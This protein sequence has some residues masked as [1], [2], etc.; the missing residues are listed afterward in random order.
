MTAGP[1]PEVHCSPGVVYVCRDCDFVDERP[2]LWC[3]HCDSGLM[4]PEAVILHR[5]QTESG[6][7][8]WFVATRVQC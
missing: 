7:V 5:G 2:H 8:R 1:T 6:R 3:P 4:V